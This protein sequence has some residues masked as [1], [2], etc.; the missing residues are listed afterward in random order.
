MEECKKKR[1]G[2]PPTTGEE[3]RLEFLKPNIMDDLGHS[4]HRER[5]RFFNDVLIESEYTNCI[6]SSAKSISLI[7]ENVPEKERFFLMDGTF[8]IT[9]QGVFQQV[10]ILQAQFGIKV[11]YLDFFEFH[12][13]FSAESAPQMKVF[14][15]IL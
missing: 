2:K 11:N 9:P 14:S 3:I 15:I 8:R 1:N 10:L 6:F 4:K 13:A 7:L 5:G 12:D